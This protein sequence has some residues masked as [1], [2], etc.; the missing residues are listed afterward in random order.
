MMIVNNYMLIA[1]VLW[2][3]KLGKQVYFNNPKQKRTTQHLESTTLTIE[4]LYLI[5]ALCIKDEV[6]TIVNMY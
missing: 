6:I 2:I 1:S 3:S 4:S 5:L